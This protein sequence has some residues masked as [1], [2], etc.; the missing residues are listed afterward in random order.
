M[1]LLTSQR[2][3]K[4]RSRQNIGEG[5]RGDGRED[6]ERERMEVNVFI[7]HQVLRDGIYTLQAAGHRTGLECLSC[8]NCLRQRIKVFESAEVQLQISEIILP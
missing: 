3:S 4:P 2:P 1:C 6:R 7:K 5:E 8:L